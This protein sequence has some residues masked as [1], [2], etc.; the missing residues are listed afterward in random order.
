LRTRSRED[1]GVG[2]EKKRIV[3]ESMAAGASVARVPQAHGVHVSQIHAWRKTSAPKRGRCVNLLPGAAR[4]F[5]AKALGHH[6]IIESSS[7]ACSVAS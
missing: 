2:D 6:E 3:Q 1:S 7:N 5:L 4:D